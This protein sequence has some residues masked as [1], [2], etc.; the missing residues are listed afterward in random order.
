MRLQHCSV[1]ELGYYAYQVAKCSSPATVSLE[2]QIP[3]IEGSMRDSRMMSVHI[4]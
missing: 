3:A 2:P 1:S 4:E